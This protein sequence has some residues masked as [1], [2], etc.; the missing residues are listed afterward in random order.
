MLLFMMISVLLPSWAAHAEVP[1]ISYPMLNSSIS[2]QSAFDIL[3]REFSIFIPENDK[4]IEKWRKHYL[5]DR[6]HLKS[7]TENMLPFIPLILKKIKEKNLPAEL[8]IIPMVESCYRINEGS[9]K[10]AIGLWQINAITAVE[11][12]L[13]DSWNYDARLDVVQTTEAALSYLKKLHHQFKS[14]PLVFAAY[15][16][17]PSR[18]KAALRKITYRCDADFYKL[19]LP[20]ETLDFVPK[21]LALA[22]IVKYHEFYD[23][24][25]PQIVDELVV[26]KCSHPIDFRDVMLAFSVPLDVL[27]KYNPGF[28]MCMIPKN[29][30]DHVI[31]APRSYL[32]SDLSVVEDKLLY[33]NKKPIYTVKRGDSLVKIASKFNLTVNHLKDHNQLKSTIIHPGQL[34]YIPPISSAMVKYVEHKVKSG[35]TLSSIAYTYETTAQHIMRTNDLKSSLIRVN[36]ILQISKGKQ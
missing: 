6:Y 14:W 21:I 4:H 17:G 5:A 28:S 9:H 33:Y 15:N 18:V 12:Q 25:G 30:N 24:T 31:L 35:E 29:K 19:D 16:A 23:L 36:Q 26:I 32:G 10:G 7:V 27:I 3:S 22:Q 13:V 20:K 34:I 8:A 11:F 2:R 1:V